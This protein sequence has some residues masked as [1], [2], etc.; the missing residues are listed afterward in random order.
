[1]EKSRDRVLS[2]EELRELWPALECLAADVEDETDQAAQKRR[3]A[4]A[5]V[6]PATAQALQV[7][8]LTAQRPGE[9][10]KMRWADVDLESGWWTI[11]A[12]VAK[13][14]L[15]HRAPLTRPVSEIL[16]RHREL[17]GEN[18]KVVFENRRGAGS[19]AHRAKKA[20]SILCR[21]LSFAF[22]AHDLRRTAST[23]MA[24]AGVP[25]D[26]IAKV[27]NHIEGGPAATRIYDRYAYDKE[28]RDALER[29]ERR[30]RA[31]VEGRTAKV[32]SMRHG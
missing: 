6:T 26:H 32:V 27:L 8:L 2:D 9:T 29:W 31:I 5:R 23:G 18:A 3:R 22:R 28:K 10:Q 17:G 1:M 20:A 4:K 14:E 7:Q 15:A 30:L 21:G 24:E 12:S 13:N 16:Q 11:P 19:I 25:R